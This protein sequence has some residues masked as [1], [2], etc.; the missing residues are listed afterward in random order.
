MRTQLPS[1]KRGQSPP[2]FRPMSILWP[3]SWMD[4]DATWYGGRPPPRPHCARWGHTPQKRGVQSPRLNFWP[5][6][7]VAKRLDGSRCHLVRRQASAQATLCYM[8][9]S[10]L[11]LSPQ[12]GTAP[13]IFGRCL[14][15]PNGRPSQLLLSTCCYRTTEEDIQSEQKLTK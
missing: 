3:N 2:N 7:V 6:S 12:R 11:P 10:S 13:Q 4:Q 1:P 14:L 5:M 15:W 9:S 8:G